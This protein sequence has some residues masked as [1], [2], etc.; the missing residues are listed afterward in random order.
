MGST[1]GA[2]VSSLSDLDLIAQYKETQDPGIVAV[3]FKRYTRMIF[4]NCFKILKNKQDSEDASADIYIELCEKLLEHDIR[5]FP[6]WLYRLTFNHC[7]GKLRKSGK[8][9]QTDI[10]DEKNRNEFMEKPEFDHQLD[11]TVSQEELLA[12]G[13]QSLESKQRV[14]IELFYLQKQSYKDISD[15]TGFDVNKVKSYI[16]NGK[17]NLRIFLDNYPK[18]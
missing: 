12:E 8:I 11:E 17:R 10:D 3:L 15:K 14:C 6:S 18:G 5:N 2:N 9:V 7:V 4:G 1:A 13:I 16:Q